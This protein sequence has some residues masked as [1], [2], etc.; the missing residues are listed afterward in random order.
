VILNQL[1]S[2]IQDPIFRT[3]F[4]FF[5]LLPQSM[6]RRREEQEAI[7]PESSK[8]PKT[9]ETAED[10]YRS[11]ALQLYA[12]LPSDLA[13][14]VCSYAKDEPPRKFILFSSVTLRTDEFFNTTVSIEN[15]LVD[16][17]VLDASERIELLQHESVWRDPRPAMKIH[18]LIDR[19]D[20]CVLSID[21]QD[22]DLTQER[23]NGQI[24]GVFTCYHH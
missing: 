15:H 12:R 22:R 19:Q 24:T 7:E 17:I 4:F 6:K 9:Q 21:R 1:K 18:D 20:P 10:L 3:A 5:F 23:Y 2:M 11:V 16:E 14:L 13:G 8:K